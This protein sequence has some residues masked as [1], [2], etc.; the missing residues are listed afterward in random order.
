[1]SA[2]AGSSRST[3]ADPNAQT[4][5][6][7]VVVPLKNW[8]ELVDDPNA[9]VVENTVLNE[10]QQLS[11]LGLM[12]FST[13]T[14]FDRNIFVRACELGLTKALSAL[15]RRLKEIHGDDYD[16]KIWEYLDQPVEVDRE[17]LARNLPDSFADGTVNV[18]TFC[19]S[20]GLLSGVRILVEE[21]VSEKNRPY[22]LTFIGAGA[23]SNAI[24]N[25]TPLSHKSFDD[26]AFRA[27]VTSPLVFSIVANRNKITLYCLQNGAVPF[28]NYRHDAV[29]THISGVHQLTALWVIVTRRNKFLLNQVLKRK[30]Y[31]SPFIEEGMMQKSRIKTYMHGAIDIIKHAL[32]LSGAHRRRGDVKRDERRLELFAAERAALDAAKFEFVPNPDSR[33]NETQREALESKNFEINNQALKETVNAR[34]A[35]L[36]REI[37]DAH[38]RTGP[39]YTEIALALL[40]SAG[41]TFDWWPDYDD[42]DHIMGVNGNLFDRE[43]GHADLVLNLTGDGIDY[44]DG[45]LL[46]FRAI[47][48]RNDLVFDNI[49]PGIPVFWGSDDSNLYTVDEKESLFEK[50][51]SDGTPKMVDYY[52]N[53]HKLN[54]F[55]N[56]HVTAPYKGIFGDI[57]S[58]SRISPESRA[59]RH[60]RNNADMVVPIVQFLLDIQTR[61]ASQNKIRLRDMKALRDAMGYIQRDFTVLHLAVMTNDR[62]IVISAVSLWNQIESLEPSFVSPLEIAVMVDAP[63]AFYTL[64]ALGARII[65]NDG[66]TFRKYTHPKIDE[67]MVKEPFGTVSNLK[68]ISLRQV[69]NLPPGEAE[70]QMRRL[71]KLPPTAKV[72]V[73]RILL[74]PG[75]KA[76]TETVIAPK[77]RRPREKRDSTKP[78]ATPT[79][80]A[81]EPMQEGSSPTNKS[82]PGKEQRHEAQIKE[83]FSACK[84]GDAA[85]ISLLLRQEPRLIKAKLRD[86]TT[87]NEYFRRHNK[88]TLSVQL[89]KF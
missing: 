65:E 13:V 72:S 60:V 36:R 5:D 45:W 1:M 51:L 46:L 47:D 42:D 79:K 83:I 56:D 77:M 76:N 74:D 31:V 26:R 67:R 44:T 10:L 2:E 11:K 27:T 70:A 39:L 68:A 34:E 58:E 3:M 30:F 55:S 75:F 62:D 22:F 23:V 37:L 14:E 40:K 16:S 24:R 52:V 35:A 28:W 41:N 88:T 20:A 63:E 9:T 18:L 66:D 38:E 78:D 87:V 25:R 64:A 69:R 43:N 15:I 80:R 19:L 86:G 8:N 85:K 33:V 29:D 54:P 12:A 7:A 21:A 17:L 50:A 4:T 84:T 48:N 82:P 71:L 57:L 81:R 53:T 61:D 49:A 32:D 6:D 73:S 59:L 89:N